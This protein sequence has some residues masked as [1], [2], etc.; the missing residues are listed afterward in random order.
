M[1]ERERVTLYLRTHKITR[2]ELRQILNSITSATNLREYAINQDLS[3]P[4]AKAR[5]LAGNCIF[6]ITN[7]SIYQQKK[8]KTKNSITTANS[9]LG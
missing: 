8:E 2:E 1:T 3:W 6:C 9:A 5:F 7:N 4:S